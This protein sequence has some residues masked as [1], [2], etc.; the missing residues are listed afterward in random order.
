MFTVTMMR[1][2]PTTDCRLLNKSLFQQ[3]VYGIPDLACLHVENQRSSTPIS[4]T[5]HAHRLII[6]PAPTW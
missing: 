2:G 5:P 6:A 3:T 1:L 4:L